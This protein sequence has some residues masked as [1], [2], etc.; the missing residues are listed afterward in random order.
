MPSTQLAC[1][2]VIVDAHNDL[3]ME[4]AWREDEGEQNPFAEQWLP[5]L[6]AGGVELQVCPM[7]V[8]LQYLPEAAL[9]IALKQAASFW[10]AVRANAGAVRPIL[11]RDDLEGQGI[12]LLLSLEGAEPLGSD[13]ALIDAFWRLGVRMVGL[14]W[15]RRNAF[16]EGAAERGGLS[17]LGVELVERI[18]KLGAIVDLAHASE[19]TF[20]DVLEQ[21][22]KP[23]LVVS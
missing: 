12:G 16:A 15:N 5:K 22:G 21:P 13:P 10:R 7:F 11:G 14:T 19:R 23:A 9:R 4:I 6:R 20:A 3:L 1:H 2:T 18:A 8:E 17:A